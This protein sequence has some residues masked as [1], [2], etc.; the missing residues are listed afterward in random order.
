MPV[1][2]I[3]ATKTTIGNATHYA[4]QNVEFFQ[5]NAECQLIGASY[6]F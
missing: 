1:D 4:S 5:M 3:P 2:V 6:P